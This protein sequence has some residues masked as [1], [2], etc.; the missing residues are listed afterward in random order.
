M[1]ASLVKSLVTAFDR[2]QRVL[3]PRAKVGGQAVLLF[4]ALAIVV[5]SAIAGPPSTSPELMDTVAPQPYRNTFI[6]RDGNL[7][8]ETGAGWMDDW[9]Y[10]SYNLDFPEAPRVIA[11][12]QKSGAKMAAAVNHST[13]GF[14]LAINDE[15]GNT[16]TG[17]WVFW[18]AVYPS[19]YHNASTGVWIESGSGWMSNY[20]NISYNLD[21]PG[22]PRVVSSAQKGGNAIMSC[23]MNHDADGFTLLLKDHNGQS[24]TDAW[25]FWIAVYPL[26]IELDDGLKIEMLGGWRDNGEYVS[27][28]ITTFPEAPHV[29]TCAQSNGACMS[30]PVSH[31]TS[32]FTFSLRDYNGDAV[33]NAWT[34]GMAVYPR[35][36]YV[37]DPQEQ[38]SICRSPS[39]LS[40]TCCQG[41]NASSQSFEV[42]NC[43][44]GTLNY[45]ISDNASWLSCSPS[46][47]SSTGEHD[48]IS[49]NYSTSGLSCGSYSGTITITDPAADNSPQTI[50]VNLTVDC[51]SICRS[52]TSLTN[53]CNEGQDA[54]SQL[55]QVWNCGCGTLNYSITDNAGW[56]SCSPTSGTSTG[57]QDT[58]N[59]YYSTSGLSCGSYSG[60][61]TITGNADNTPQT[62]SVNLTVH[63]DEPLICYYPTSLSNSCEEGQNAP[64]QTFEVWNCGNGT[65]SYSISD[66]VTWL[67][68][69]PSSGTSTGEHDTITVIYSTESLPCGGSPYSGTITITASGAEN[70]PQT[71][72]V[73]LTVTCAADTY[74]TLEWAPVQ[75]V[76]DNR[77]AVRLTAWNT[78]SSPTGDRTLT[79]KYGVEILAVDTVN[80][81]A[82][83]SVEKRLFF[84]T[85]D[86]PVSSIDLEA[87]LDPMPGE[88]NTA[89][90]SLAIPMSVLP[91]SQAQTMVFTEMSRIEDEYG[92][93]E[94][95]DLAYD[96]V[97]F[98]TDA[99]VVGV[100]VDVHSDPTCVAAY[101]Q[102]DA[103]PSDQTRAN[104][105]VAAIDTYVQSRLDCDYVTVQYLMVVGADE[106]VPFRRADAGNVFP[107]SAYAPHIPAN[108]RLRA[109]FNANMFPSDSYYADAQN[110]DPPVP[111]YAIGRLVE[112]PDQIV[113]VIEQFLIDGPSITVND[114]GLADHTPVDFADPA[115]T[116][117]QTVFPAAGIHA[118]GSVWSAAQLQDLFC[119]APSKQYLGV[120]P[121]SRHNMFQAPDGTIL[122]A[123]ITN[124][125]VGIDGALTV[126][127][128]CHA[129]LATW[130]DEDWPEVFL[131]GNAN[132]MTSNTTYGFRSAT[133][134]L[135]VYNVRLYRDLV[136][137]LC[138]GASI[139]QALTY[140]KVTFRTGPAWWDNAGGVCRRVLLGSTLYGIPHYRYDIRGAVPPARGRLVAKSTIPSK[141]VDVEYLAT[142]GRRALVKETR[143]LYPGPYI[144]YSDGSGGV[145]YVGV[146]EEIATAVAVPV[147]PAGRSVLGQTDVR[148]HGALIT[149]EQH[150]D[151]MVQNITLGSASCADGE[152]TGEFAEDIWY[153]AL[154]YRVDSL[155]GA[156]QIVETL[157]PVT[158]Q[159]HLATETLRLYDEITYDIYYS[160]LSDWV[161]PAV[162]TVY[163]APADPIPDEPVTIYVAAADDSGVYAVV[164]R[165]SMDEGD[166]W[167]T[168]TATYNGGTGMWEVTIT[169]P[170]YSNGVYYVNVV[171]N[172]GNVTTDKNDGEF[173]QLGSGSPDCLLYDMNYDGFVSIIGDVPPFVQVVYFNDY[174]WYEQQFPGMD[175][176]CPGDCNGDGFL[177]II[178]DVPCFVDCVYFGNCP[179]RGDQGGDGDGKEQANG[180]F[181]IGG[182]VYSDLGNPLGSGLEGVRIQVT[183]LTA[184]A[185][186]A[187]TDSEVLR[188]P[189]PATLTGTAP[190]AQWITASGALGLWQIDG[191][192]PG[193][194]AV[195]ASAPGW[196]LEHMQAG[197]GTGSPRVKIVVDAPNQAGNQSI[198]FLASE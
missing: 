65:L 192:R 107:E 41:Q 137:R 38:P 134:G 47:G 31:S 20:D 121:H 136:E 171:D 42:W 33:D 198:Q 92:T 185:L 143:I 168:H 97:R 123:T 78:G 82:D 89:N 169:R 135:P 152:M 14:Y 94:C 126:S 45:S 37:E 178:G 63:C 59:V 13:D 91:E 101:S 160:D 193:W 21:F 80:I 100:M 118:L 104:N 69:T 35:Y 149:D 186:T 29:V 103:S 140:S 167:E 9:D 147:F 66:D 131:A 114:V 68:C 110:T 195:T 70:S 40:P 163:H 187:D 24:V 146:S 26:Q 165:T 15:N 10:I 183:E 11:C 188:I 117:F 158:A 142:G 73:S 156:G 36:G 112:T 106:I 4:C 46:S 61:I 109:T 12:A 120:Y 113:G 85:E 57:E 141:T 115:Q 27:Y 197:V 148:A 130:H 93:G 58:I 191:L 54:P 7:M 49:V 77:G 173:Y 122:T 132:G 6:S 32:G 133:P 30:C 150:A 180:T 145:Y 1:Q 76:R 108:S 164:I 72:S 98:T 139:G 51:P 111:D 28:D 105:V 153:P 74:L 71:I 172:A 177:S 99:T 64:S 159:Y 96:L 52:P 43:G 179:R 116:E 190:H 75:I 181:T 189:D 56:L 34:F 79:L 151:E 88:Q 53:E 184:A 22:A 161:P 67:S 3:W 39:S 144:Q 162:A 81:P 18:I 124:V 174:E 175:P 86:L 50:G 60:T 176:V 166:N 83:G 154:E 182:A 8:I 44:S 23:P 102:W 48:T 196:V 55:F 128:G 16:V 62:I 17:A 119:T 129:G 5:P 155:I 138:E 194:Y 84:A 2:N 90:N 25:T 157:V 127:N 19:Q 87:H 170:D 95:E 125:G